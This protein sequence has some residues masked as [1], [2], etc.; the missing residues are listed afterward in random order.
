M[1]GMYV[2]YVVRPAGCV[3]VSQCETPVPMI[4]RGPCDAARGICVDLWGC[5]NF[6]NWALQ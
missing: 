6:E 4:R 2:L 5:Q 1:L 3:E